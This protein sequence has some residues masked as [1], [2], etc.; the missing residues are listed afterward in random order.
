MRRWSTKYWK[1]NW[2]RN[3]RIAVINDS[4]WCHAYRWG[5]GGGGGERRR[6]SE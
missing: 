2:R 4:N 3:H 1:M 5:G 6:I